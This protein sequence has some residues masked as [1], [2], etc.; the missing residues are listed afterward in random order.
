MRR[1]VATLHDGPLGGGMAQTF[2]L[3]TAALASG[4]YVVRARSG[5]WSARQTVT[6]VR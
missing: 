1:R 2:T 6:L 3:D 5:A 4:V